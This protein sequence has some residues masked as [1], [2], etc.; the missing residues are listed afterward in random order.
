[1]HC[2]GRRCADQSTIFI[3]GNQPPGMRKSNFIIEDTF[4]SIQDPIISFALAN[5]QF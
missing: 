1:M 3:F 2:I 4:H 5:R